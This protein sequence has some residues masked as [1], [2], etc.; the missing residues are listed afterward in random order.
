MRSAR[1]LG[2]LLFVSLLSGPAHAFVYPEHRDI[3]AAAV[4]QLSNSDRAALEKLWSTGREVFRG[5]LCDTAGARTATKTTMPTCLDF[6]DLTALSGD[7]SCSPND[8]VR[9]VLPGGWA[10]GV[11]RVAAETKS[12]F[13]KAG[14]PSEVSNRLASMHLELQ[15]VDPE[16]LSR[17]GANAAHFLLA[18]E[19]DRLALYI[20]QSASAGAPLNALG[21]YLQYHLAA[22]A[23]AQD[24]ARGTLGGT[25]RAVAA[26]DVVALEGYAC[27]WLEDMFASGHAAGTWGDDS[28]RKGTHDYYN[29]HGLDMTTWAGERMVAFGD[30]HLKNADLARA[31][32]AVATS[33]TQVVS[34]LQPGNPLAIAAQAFGPGAQA[35]FQ[36]DSCVAS[37]QPRSSGLAE[38]STEPTLLALLATLPTPGRGAHDVHLPRFREEF[39]P[40]IGAFGGTASSIAGGGVGAQGVRP[41]VEL[42][43]GVRFGY[44]A[45]AI[46]GNVGTSKLFLEGGFTMQSSQVQS[47]EEC[48]KNPLYG[49]LPTVPPRMGMRFGVRLPFYLVPGDLVVLAPLLLAVS[50]RA[51][52]RVGITAIQGG[53]VPYERSF[54]TRAGIFQ[55]VAGRE[56]DF[57]FFGY[58]TDTL[59][60]RAFEV[61]RTGV[62]EGGVVAT[63]SMRTRLPLLE[64][65]PL[66]SFTTNVTFAVPVQ[67]GVGFEV[68]LS[69]RVVYPD[70]VED[71]RPG[72]S[73]NAFLRLRIDAQHFF[74][75]RE[76]LR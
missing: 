51:L 26:R 54:R 18:R 38:I 31:S 35:A 76:D 53:L 36:L 6:G 74:G 50:P 2:P 57:T 39:G 17:A 72:V 25:P 22:L 64:W 34:A 73:W 7:H 29:E 45:P 24:L 60:V 75:A 68:P 62:Q 32:R 58:L 3:G 23:L 67:I 65:T 13:R 40:F 69:A 8:V 70:G 61:G 14:S 71:P 19:S 56:A 59:E 16:Y 42:E 30:A 48:E 46:S 33:L 49:L 20:V 28:W 11:A 41:S 52:T 15:G 63:R 21:L 47:C 66:R 1:C 12:A 37:E 43:T 10:L 27:H 5:P 44:A 55:I 4:Q 9:N